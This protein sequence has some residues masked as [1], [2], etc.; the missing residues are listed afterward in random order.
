M[1]T[2]EGIKSFYDYRQVT[3]EKLNEDTDKLIKVISRI[4]NKIFSFCLYQECKEVYDTVAGVELSNVSFSNVI[5]PLLN[6]DS[7]SS[8]Q[9]VALVL[10]GMVAT[11]KELRDASSEAEKKLEEFE[12]EMSMRK[13]VFD[14]VQAFS[15]TDEAKTLSPELKR[16]VEKNVRDGKRNGLHLDED[17]REEIKNV[18]KRIS[19]LGVKFN[20]N[21]NEDTTFLLFDQ[22]E[23]TGVPEDLVNSFDKDEE[24]GKLKV[25]MK[26]PHFF[27]VTRKCNNPETRLKMEQTYQSRC[28]E[29]NTAILEEIVVLR[30]KQA[31]LLGYESH[32]AYIQEIR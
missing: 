2:F 20:K 30:Q 19:E 25:T 11:S 5:Q 18:K 14:R 32:A 15:E 21:L 23:L 26:Y 4:I 29:E 24:T 7:D 8:H 17:K 27:P 3:V 12:V 1:T 28:M 10:P 9:S 31:E 22:S 16:Y 6:V 13:D